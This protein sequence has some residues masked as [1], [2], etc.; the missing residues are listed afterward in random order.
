M[1]TLFLSVA[2]LLI[3]VEESSGQCPL[4]LLHSLAP[5]S[6]RS[7]S[8]SES[9]FSDGSNSIE[10]VLLT[11][12]CCWARLDDGLQFSARIF[13]FFSCDVT[14]SNNSIVGGS[15]P[16]TSNVTG[17]SNSILVVDTDAV[18]SISC[19]C[20]W[21]CIENWTKSGNS[22]EHWLQTNAILSMDMR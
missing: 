19:K 1:D 11:I 21:T 10:F 9:M 15:S 3:F 6:K 14:L 5:S 22:A 18:T 7:K 8:W 13:F 16:A 2:I 20:D 17:S 4:Q 12:G